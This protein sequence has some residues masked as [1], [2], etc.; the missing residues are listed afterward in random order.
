MRKVFLLAAVVAALIVM[1]EPS[2]HAQA[3]QTYYF[4]TT[5]PF[6]CR[7]TAQTVTR[8]CKALTA[9]M[10]TYVTDGILTNG[11]GT[12]QTLKLVTGTGTDCATGTAD[13]THAVQFGAAVGNFNLGPFHTPLQPAA[14]G[15]AVCVA[16]SAATSYSVTISGFQVPAS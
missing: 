1:V 16:P 15:L 14:A 13:L 11:V 5:V 10:K 2:L 3:T 6:T 12:A 4:S 7:I 9:G 8:E